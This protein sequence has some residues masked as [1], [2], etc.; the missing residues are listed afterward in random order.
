MNPAFS[1]TTRAI[2]AD[3]GPALA[4]VGTGIALVGAWLAWAA[5]GGITLYESSDQGLV[6]TEGTVR[7]RAAA[8]GLVETVEVDLGQRVDAGQVLVRLDAAGPTLSLRAAEAEAAGLRE[9]LARMDSARSSEEAGREA[10]DRARQADLSRARAD[11]IEVEVR[12]TEARRELAGLESLAARGAAAVSQVERARMELSA[13]QARLA[14]ADNEVGRL[15]G[16]LAQGTHAGAAEADHRAETRATL[17]AALAVAEAEVARQQELLDQRTLR[18][19]VDGVLAELAPL[20]TGQRV[21]AG[22]LLAVVVPDG[23]P[24]VVARFPAENAVGRIRPGQT[25]TVRV[26]GATGGLLGAR[27]AHVARVGSDPG[28]DGRVPVVLDLERDAADLHHGL[29]AAVEVAVERV[30]P[31]EL[32]LR[33]SSPR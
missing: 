22:A 33:T 8:T 2:G 25:A 13:L 14:A 17:Q 12:V 18:A 32:L 19:P 3:R 29:P 30:R 16:L 15:S 31:L 10:A 1:R 23:S 9:Q 6:Q 7:L 21:E 28:Q 27:Q 11:R 4:V 20:A 24:Q 26:A 5:V